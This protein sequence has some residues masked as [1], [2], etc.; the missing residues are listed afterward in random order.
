MNNELL[1]RQHNRTCI[2]YMPSTFR[3]TLYRQRREIC[4]ITLATY[5]FPAKVSICCRRVVRTETAIQRYSSN[6]WW[7]TNFDKTGCALRLGRRL[8]HCRSLRLPTDFHMTQDQLRGTAKKEEKN[9]LKREA[10]RY[11][12]SSYYSSDFAGKTRMWKEIYVYRDRRSWKVYRH[13]GAASQPF[14]GRRKKE[15]AI[16]KIHGRV[17]Q[18]VCWYRLSWGNDTREFL[19]KLSDLMLDL[20]SCGMFLPCQYSAWLSCACSC[21]AVSAA[22]Y[23]VY[24]GELMLM[25]SICG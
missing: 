25:Q 22:V 15:F 9:I 24:D 20:Q 2:S 12:F 4:Y 13:T 10:G 16:A 3:W 1:E 14:L 7:L 21:A 8:I 23:I 5:V 11:I 6:C 19:A 18:R 17:E